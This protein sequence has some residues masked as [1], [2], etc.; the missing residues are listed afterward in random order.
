MYKQGDDLHRP[1]NRPQDMAMKI[2]S[3]TGILLWGN[4]LT[5]VSRLRGI[6]ATIKFIDGA[7][8]L[9]PLANG[10]LGAYSNSIDVLFDR[11]PFLFLARK[12]RCLLRG[13]LIY[14]FGKRRGLDI[15]LQFG[16]RKTKTGLDTH[17]WITLDRCV[18]F[19]VKE[20]IDQYTMLVEYK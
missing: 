12:Q 11:F 7:V 16:S 20:V 3:F 17:C 1:G 2:F 6:T 10:E 8:D 9:L 5:I 13:L 4:L 15:R 19:E 14:F 18:Q